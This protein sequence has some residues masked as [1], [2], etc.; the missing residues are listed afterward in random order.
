[1]CRL[2]PPEPA[3]LSLRRVALWERVGQN[4]VPEKLSLS[5]VHPSAPQGRLAGGAGPDLAVLPALAA[6]AGRGLHGRAAVPPVPAAARH[7]GPAQGARLRLPP[8]R[9]AGNRGETPRTGQRSPLG[10]TNSSP[11]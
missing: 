9:A 4:R 5:P 6:A 3:G 8:P 7:R 1:M 2:M 10:M 11:L